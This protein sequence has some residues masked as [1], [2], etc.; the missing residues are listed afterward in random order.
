MAKRMTYTRADLAMFWHRKGRPT[1]LLFRPD[2][3]LLNLLK[4]V[5]LFVL[6]VRDL[7]RT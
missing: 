3:V 1:M 5:Q 2:K 6:F 4:D 7:A